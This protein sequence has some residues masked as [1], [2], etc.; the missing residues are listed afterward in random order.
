MIYAYLR[1]S[2]ELQDEANQ[3]LGVEGKAKQLGVKIDRF[4]VDK[5]SGTKPVAERNLGK[6]LN[7][8]QDGDI[9]IVSEISR[10][11]RRLYLLFNILERLLAKGCKLY[12][13]KDGYTLDQ[14]IQ[15]KV[16]AFAFGMAAEI[17]RDMISKRTK[18]ALELRRRQGIKLGRP[19]GSISKVSK[20][21]GKE[22]LINRMHKQGHRRSEIARRCHCTLDTLNVYIRR[23]PDF[24]TNCQF[25]M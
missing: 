20:L 6:L 2:T 7:R 11:A 12:S 25:G 14:T 18:E 4:V 13:V 5:T 16:L 19:I 9:I 23:H 15:S 17:E 1:V 8:I 22:A 21:D 24:F 3:R 10:L